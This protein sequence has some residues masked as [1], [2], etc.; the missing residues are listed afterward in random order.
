MSDTKLDT[1]IEVDTKGMLPE[2]QV[3]ERP[4][5]VRIQSSGKEKDETFRQL[6]ALLEIFEQP[7]KHSMDSSSFIRVLFGD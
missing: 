7:N 3:K 6:S 1:V 5:D 2:K 4:H